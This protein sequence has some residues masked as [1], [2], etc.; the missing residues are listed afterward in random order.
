[1]A[2]IADPGFTLTAYGQGEYFELAYSHGMKFLLDGSADRLWATYVPPLTLD[3]VSIY[4]RGPVLG[5]VL[6]RRGV[7]SLH[8]SAV[9]VGG[10]AIALCGVSEAGKSTTAAA[11]ALRGVPVLSEDIA[12]LKVENGRFQ[13][14]PGYPRI[15]LWPDSAQALLG[16]GA[17][18]PRMAPGWEKCYLPLDGKMA[19]FEPERKPLGAVYVLAP[20]AAEANAPRIEEVSVREALLDLVQNTYMNWLLDRNQR[21]AEF[22]LLSRLVVQVPVRRIVPHVDPA[23][24]GALCDLIVGDAERLSPARDSRAFVSG[25]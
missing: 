17:A 12:A 23:R 15:C 16:A 25:R 1:M 7:S 4:F 11:L 10:H 2:E 8:A 19:D 13:I 21:A 18:L 5:F 3:D 6:G 24:I 22:D 9:C 20:R 14:E